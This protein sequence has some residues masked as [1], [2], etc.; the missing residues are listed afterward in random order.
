MFLQV[1][2]DF[3][4]QAKGDCSGRLVFGWFAGDGVER[5]VAAR[6]WVG[7]ALV[8]VFVGQVFRFHPVSLSGNE[9]LVAYGV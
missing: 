5:D 3:V 7:E 4:V 2:D 8:P 1:F 6:V 9:D